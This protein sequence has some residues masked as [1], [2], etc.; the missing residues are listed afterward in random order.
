MEPLLKIKIKPAFD[1]AVIRQSK[2]VLGLFS[3]RK[4]AQF[5]FAPKAAYFIFQ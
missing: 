4:L 5:F 1:K 3:G 2:P